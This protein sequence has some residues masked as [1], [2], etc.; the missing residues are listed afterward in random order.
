MK[1]VT[2][3]VIMNK[4]EEANIQ[5]YNYEEGGKVCGYELNTYTGCGVN[6][7]LF[8]DFRG[9]E[10]NPNRGDDFLSLFDERVKSIDIDEEIVMLMNDKSYM[11]QIGI[12]K[13]IKDLEQWKRNLKNIFA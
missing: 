13:G 7:I 1:K 3:S 8:I 11:Q 2:I 6:Q 4:L 10:L 12:K 5:V 9:T